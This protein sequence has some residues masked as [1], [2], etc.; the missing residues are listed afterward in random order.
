MNKKKQ[1]AIITGGAKRVGAAICRR[2]HKANVDLII[3]YKNSKTE[4]NSL[5]KELNKSRKGSAKIIQADLLDPN[6]YS[7]I[8]NEAIKIYGQLN[9]LI[10]NASSYYPTK[11]NDI[12]E[13]NWNE[14]IATNLKASLFLSKE[15]S[16]FLK[17][18]NG[19]IINITDAHITNPKK[20]YIIYS[21]AKSGLAALT[22]SL[23]QELGPEIRV[24]AVLWPD[25]SIE[26]DETY[27]KKVISQTML[28]KVG[29]A[30][31]IAKAVEFL[32][33][34]APFITSHILNVDG[35]RSFNSE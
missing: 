5:Q 6:S 23:A 31:D 4:A 15:A 21:I 25:K 1:V 33:L 10:N 27:R 7:L 9:F 17:K 16:P 20:N 24:N 2:L 19:S 35:G 26:F 3:H 13:A 18:S 8:I 14:L 30:D 11:I 32:L 22:K 34:N 29:D 12:D 28:K